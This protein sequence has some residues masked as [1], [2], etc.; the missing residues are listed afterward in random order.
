MTE[1]PWT[2]VADIFRQVCPRR[3]ERGHDD[4][5]CL[6]AL[7][8]FTVHN[9]TWRALPQAFGPWNSVWQ[10]VWRRSRAGVFEA[11]FQLLASCRATAALIQLFD[12]TTAYADVSAAGA[13]GGS[14]IRPW[15]ARGAGS[16]RKSMSNATST[17]CRS[18]LS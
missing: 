1:E 8:Y 15:A 5:R 10:R 2:L 6:Q 13:K 9:I 7:P 3:G 12:S 11:F 17:A 4:L 14:T 18:T 16:A